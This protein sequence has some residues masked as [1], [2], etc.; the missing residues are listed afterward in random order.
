MVRNERVSLA[1]CAIL[2]MAEIK[3]AIEAF[4]RGEVS[5]FDAL[6]TLGAAWEAYEHGVPA[7]RQAG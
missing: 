2:T 1:T 3:D 6:A 5:V 7:R 4:E